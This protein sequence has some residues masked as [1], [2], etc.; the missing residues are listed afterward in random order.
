M[1][2]FMAVWIVVKLGL[3]GDWDFNIGG[4][5]R[6]RQRNVQGIRYKQLQ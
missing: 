1:W 6:D 3:P 5:R 4:P 2:P